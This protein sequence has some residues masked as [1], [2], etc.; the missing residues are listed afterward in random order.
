[1]WDTRVSIGAAWLQGSTRQC[2]LSV[3]FFLQVLLKMFEM[4][5]VVGGGSVGGGGVG[6]GGGGVVFVLI[7][8][9]VVLINIIVI[10]DR[11]Y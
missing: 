8:V 7:L 5:V 9:L 6:V 3:F 4:F 11:P 2:P 10:M 1:M